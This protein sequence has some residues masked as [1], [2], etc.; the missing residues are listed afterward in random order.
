[1]LHRLFGKT[2]TEVHLILLTYVYKQ[3][4]TNQTIM[5]EHLRYSDNELKEFETL[6]LSKLK[7]AQNEL[8]T[9]RGML[10][11]NEAGGSR[12]TSGTHYS[13]ESGA[14]SSQREEINALAARQ[15][16]YITSLE[17]A[18]I[19]ISLLMLHMQNSY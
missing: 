15:K 8:T 6:I 14:E 13:L 18:L 12:I 17:N 19:R 10:N 1:M 9:Y 7:V 3:K 16:K 4:N 5:K 11:G 2:Q